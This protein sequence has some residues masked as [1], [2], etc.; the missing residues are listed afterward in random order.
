MEEIF[1]WK[2]RT[3]ELTILILLDACDGTRRSIKQA[4]G[5]QMVGAEFLT[6]GAEVYRLAGKGRENDLSSRPFLAGL[7]LELETSV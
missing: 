7:G 5:W 2:I 3:A 4:N 6:A 1:L